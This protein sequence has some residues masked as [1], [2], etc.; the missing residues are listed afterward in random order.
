MITAA[1]AK[2]LQSKKEYAY[3]YKEDGIVYIQIS[4]FKYLNGGTTYHNSRSHYYSRIYRNGVRSKGYTSY[5]SSARQESI[6]SR[7]SS[8][9]GTSS[10]K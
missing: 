1:S 8:G 4:N 5:S 10:G 6:N 3:V 2:G 9:G 7:T